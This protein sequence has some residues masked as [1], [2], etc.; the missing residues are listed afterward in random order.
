MRIPSDSTLFEMAVDLVCDAELASYEMVMSRS[1]YAELVQVRRLVSGMLSH[2]FGWSQH[3]IAK[4]WGQDH[5]SVGHQLQQITDTEM[6]TIE[7]LTEDFIQLM[8]DN[9]AEIIARVNEVRNR[10][11]V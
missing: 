4:Q 6:E 2:R 1:R 8:R 7:S 5:T 10:N 11:A 9:Q 3:R